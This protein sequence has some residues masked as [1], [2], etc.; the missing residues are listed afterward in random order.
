MFLQSTP[1]GPLSFFKVYFYLALLEK[2]HRKLISSEKP[3]EPSHGDV[4][5]H[6]RSSPLETSVCVDWQTSFGGKLCRAP[7]RL[8]ENIKWYKWRNTS[9]DRGL[10]T[11]EDVWARLR[12]AY[13]FRS[14]KKNIL[15]IK[16]ER[17]TT[18]C[19]RHFCACCC[20]RR[21]ACATR[22]RCSSCLT[23]RNSTTCLKLPE[24]RTRSVGMNI[25]DISSSPMQQ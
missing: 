25:R 1:A 8:K 9:F 6:C 7:F 22:T 24:L 23:Q 12:L 2:F 17:E 19:V 11:A 10:S 14:L 4:I 15:I 16:K 13:M 20:F 5:H 3:K 21:D 18:S